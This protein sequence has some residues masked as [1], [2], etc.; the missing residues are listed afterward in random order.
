MNKSMHS[1]SILGSSAKGLSL[2]NPE[3][4]D[5]FNIEGVQDALRDMGLE[6]AYSKES[7]TRRCIHV[8]AATLAALPY[9]VFR[10]GA[11]DP[12]WTHED[13]PPQEYA[14]LDLYAHLY[15]S[16]AA[17]VLEGYSTAMI[18]GK[19]SPRSNEITRV[20][21]LMWLNPKTMTV[22]T[23]KGAHGPDE[24]GR[25]THWKRS[26]GGKPVWLPREWVLSTF[27]PSPYLEEGV[28]DSDAKAVRMHSQILN[29][30]AKFESD[31]LRSGLPKKT[32]F[33]TAK[34]APKNPDPET[35]K[36]L[37]R[38][39]RKFLQGTKNT[40][41][42]I[43]QGIDTKEIGS[44]LTDLHSNILTKDARE[45]IATGIGVPHSL[46]MSNAANYATAVQDMLNLLN[47]TVI[48][49]A[50]LIGRD[51]NRQFFSRLGLELRFDPKK[52]EA[53]QQAELDTAEKVYALTGKRPILS[54]RQA[55]EMLGIRYTPEDIEELDRVEEMQSRRPVSIASARQVQQ[56]A[57]RWRRR[58]MSKGRDASFS[59]DYMTRDQAE[60]IRSRLADDSIPIEEVFAGF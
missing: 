14:W 35:V 9:S 44:S 12:L 26:V 32:I 30:L 2:T 36:A 57:V 7:W 27:E 20:T 11:E 34:D 52:H 29:D 46:V 22:V 21:G 8:R 16:C 5:G 41:P 42:K 49:D 58:V 51:M 60:E 25:F 43:V 47:T 54:R 24:R 50:Q 4:W 48:P 53:F 19:K 18:E 28:G 10:V 33:I 13:E 23:E 45:A 3:G 39:I 56:D 31:Q 37:E 1:V 17:L 15:K 38:W 40:P 59:P 6:E 55:A